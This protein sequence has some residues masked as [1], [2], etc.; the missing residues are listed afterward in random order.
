MVLHITIC[1]GEPFVGLF[2]VK[3][4]YYICPTVYNLYSL[5]IKIYMI[6]YDEQSENVNDY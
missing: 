6:N 2:I 5:K 1:F 3:L 4:S